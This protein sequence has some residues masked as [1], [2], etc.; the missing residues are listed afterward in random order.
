MKHRTL[1]TLAAAGAL[2]LTLSAC[3]PKEPEATPTPEALPTESMNVIVTTPEAQPTES[4]NVIVTSPEPDPTQ[5]VN[6]IAPE[7][8]DAVVEPL[9][10]QGPVQVP[11][12]ET[13]TPAPT[14]EPT[15]EPTPEAPAASL[16]AADAYA[17]V[18]AVATSTY[19]MDSSFALDAFYPD[20]S[21][22]DF[23]DFVLYM[24]DASAKIEEILIGKVTSGRM[25]AVKTACESRQQG[26]KEDAQAYATT[27]DYVDSY[28][29]VVNGDWIMFAVVPNPAEAESAFNDYTK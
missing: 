5:S 7:E 19:M 4:M 28:K 25:D 26:M 23:E 2:L 15:P 24:P 9:E 8:T 12:M 22:A 14:A 21:E 6:V 11:P 10:S 3:S 16:T 20:L 29:L 17:K 27:G 1:L 13:L 18:S